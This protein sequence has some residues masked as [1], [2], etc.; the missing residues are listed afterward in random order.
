[1][2]AARE[3]GLAGLLDA[4]LAGGRAGE[5]WPDGPRQRLREAAVAALVRGVGQADLFARVART[6][7]GRGLR[8]LPL[9]GAAVAEWLYDSVAERPMADVDVLALDDWPSSVR[10][11]GEAGFAVLDRADHAWAFHDPEGAGIVE[12]HHGLSSCPGFF[13]VDAPGLGERSRPLSPSIGDAALRRPSAEDLLVQI[14][15]H[16]AFQHGLVLS[17][18]QHLDFRRIA[19]RATPDVA[20]A[21]AAAEAAGALDCLS[22]A[23]AAAHRVVG[24]EALRALA[25]A[26]PPA[27][28]IRGWLDVRLSDPGRL[29]VPA[30]APL[31]S[32]RW[33]LAHGRRA[34]LV[35]RTLALAGPGRPAGRTARLRGSLRRALALARH[36]LP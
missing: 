3:Q 34:E 2:D 21:R 28:R 14:A 4:A 32:T 1:M 17:L 13:R 31:A 8:A 25:A 29:L 35:T 22:A 15:V 16:A 30:P 20:R 11:L 24:G 9:K 23:L 18:V 12:L 27:R 7:A 26:F 19:E 36:A 5:A 10:A 6:L 33:A